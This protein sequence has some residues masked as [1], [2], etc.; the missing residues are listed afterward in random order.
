MKKLLIGFGVLAATVAVLPMFAAFEAHVINVTATIENAL[1]VPTESISFGTVFPQEHLN[2]ALD[3]S[4]SSSFLAEGRVDDV[5]YFIRQKPK[6]GITSQNGT[7]LDK[8]SPVLFKT[9]HIIVGNNP[10]TPEVET[11]WVDCGDA[12]R[13]LISGETWGVLPML[14]PYISKHPDDVP[15]PNDQKLNSFHQPFEI[16][17]GGIK[18]NDTAGHLAKSQQD[19][20][21]NWTVDLAVPCF[22][23]YCAQDWADFV[24]KISEN[25]DINPSDYVQ[26]KDNEHK[27]FGCDL[28]I[29]VGSI[30]LPGLGCKGKID[31]MLVLDRSGSISTSEMNTL[32]TAA[33]AFVDALLISPDGSHGGQTSFATVGTLDHHLTGDANSLKAAIDALSPG[34]YT[35]LKEGIELANGELADPTYDRTDITSP[36][37]I[38]IITDGAPN[39]PGTEA[40]AKALAKAAADAAKAAGTEVYVVG[41]GTTPSTSQWL[42]DNIVSLPVASHYFDAGDFTQLESVLKQ[43]AACEN[44]G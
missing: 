27:V 6:C 8:S 33:K 38:V 26:P 10:Q 29:E 42:K 11:Y 39:E 13:A 25:P 31:L 16:I 44:N 5:D 23:G 12:P 19:T 40:E 2:K 1:S 4:L 24:K 18:W 43:I 35:N 22:G 32:K 37:Y 20:V 17:N 30:S 7:V 15:F 14:C 28:W 41:V 34:G 21:D 3:I 36:D 9:G